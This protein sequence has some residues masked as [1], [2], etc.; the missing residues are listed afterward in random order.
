MAGGGGGGVAPAEACAANTADA[1]A[2][3]RA[4]LSWLG[5]NGHDGWFSN[6]FSVAAPAAAWPLGRGARVRSP[7]GRG[8]GGGPVARRATEGGLDACAALG[9]STTGS[10]GGGGVTVYYD[11]G[12]EVVEAS[13]Y[14]SLVADLWLLPVAVAAIALYMRR[15]FG[16][17][18]LA[19][20]A[21]LQIV[22][23]IPILFWIVGVVLGENPLSAF[24]I[25]T[26]WVVTGVSAD[27]IFVVHETWRQAHLLASAT[28][29]RRSAR[30]SHGR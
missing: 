2:E 4:E 6:G 10:G 25:T 5:A 23:S 8:G 27:N 14:A 20:L 29:A 18:A 11:A 28:S 9:A 26:L 24:C 19:L 16:S 3:L 30:G 22:F 12:D 13:L 1:T 17:W 21:P 7:M 15:Y